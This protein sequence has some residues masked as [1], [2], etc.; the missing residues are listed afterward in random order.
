M[1]FTV[2]LTKNAYP[3]TFRQIQPRDD[4]H[5]TESAEGK[6]SRDGISRGTIVT[7]RN[8]SRC[9]PVAKSTREVTVSFGSVLPTKLN[10]YFPSHKL[11]GSNKIWD[12]GLIKQFSLIS[13]YKDKSC[14]GKNV[15]PSQ[16]SYEIDRSPRPSWAIFLKE[17]ELSGLEALIF[18]YILIFHLV[19]FANL[20]QIWWFIWQSR[21][22]HA[23]LQLSRSYIVEPIW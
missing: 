16:N 6:S 19:L 8:Q 21:N 1:A 20:K 17:R 15:I 10:R 23:S 4:R 9:S 18:Y 13:F 2:A 7:W 5:V 12:L 3:W 11:G 22:N 14:A